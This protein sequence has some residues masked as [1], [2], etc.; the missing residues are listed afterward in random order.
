MYMFVV[1]GGVIYYAVYT[2]TTIITYEATTTTVVMGTTRFG[3]IIYGLIEQQQTI[4]NTYIQHMK[5]RSQCFRVHD[6]FSLS[7]SLNAK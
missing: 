1:R 7:L 5:N 3:I 4:Q 2:T 6:A